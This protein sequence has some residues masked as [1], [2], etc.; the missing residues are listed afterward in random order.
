MNKKE[1]YI[2]ISALK[3]YALDINSK[4]D[5]ASFSNEREDLKKEMD[6]TIVLA[7]KLAEKWD[8]PLC[9][10]GEAFAELL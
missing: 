9:N 8:L 4:A 6:E 2:V 10:P 5:Q 3:T 7:R 1:Q